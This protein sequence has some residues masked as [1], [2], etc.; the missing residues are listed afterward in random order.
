MRIRSA[1][2]GIVRDTL[3]SNE[4]KEYFYAVTDYAGREGPSKGF[5]DLKRK[6][7]VTT[8]IYFRDKASLKNTWSHSIFFLDSKSPLLRAAFQS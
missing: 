3:I 6:L 2:L 7:G 8:H 1:H 5:W 4:F